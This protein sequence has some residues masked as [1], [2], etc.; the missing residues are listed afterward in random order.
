MEITRYATQDRKF[1]NDNS[2]GARFYFA[3]LH[4]QSISNWQSLFEK[5]IEFYHETITLLMLEFCEVIVD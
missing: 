5:K 1:S 2:I 3:L 4:K